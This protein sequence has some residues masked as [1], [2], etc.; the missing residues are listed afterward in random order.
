[1]AETPVVA[2]ARLGV[3]LEGKDGEVTY[4]YFE[5]GDEVKGVG[6]TKELVA[7]WRENG[8]VGDPPAV[9]PSVAAEKEA[10]E[11]RVAELEK[12]LDDAKKAQQEKK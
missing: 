3:E 2:I 6:V 5:P 1:M 9:L 4:K 11:A 8:S 12:Q 7:Q 10:L